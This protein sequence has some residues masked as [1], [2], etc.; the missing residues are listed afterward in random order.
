MRKK[1]FKRKFEKNSLKKTTAIGPVS[2]G[3]SLR[4]FGRDNGK[5]SYDDD[6]IKNL[7]DI[8]S[9]EGGKLIPEH[10]RNGNKVNDSVREINYVLSIQPNK[11]ES[12]FQFYYKL[13]T[14]LNLYQ[15]VYIQPFWDKKNSEKLKSIYIYDH[16]SAEIIKDEKNNYWIKL[17]LVGGNFVIKKYENIV[18]IKN[19]MYQGIFG[20]NVNIDLSRDVDLLKADKESQ[21]KKL[22]NS[23]KATGLLQ[24]TS[25]LGPEQLKEKRQQFIETN[26]TENDTSFFLIDGNTT[27]TELKTQFDNL[28]NDQVGEVKESLRQFFNISDAILNATFNSEQYSAFYKLAIEPF[29]KQLG[30]AFTLGIFTRDAINKGNKIIF[31]QA[32]SYFSSTKEK[33]EYVKV[34]IESGVYTLNELRVMLGLSKFTNLMLGLKEYDLNPADVPRVHLNNVS[35]NIADEYQLN[36]DGVE[37]EKENGD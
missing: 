18:H 1:L 32:T 2:F 8:I 7:L 24:S 11:F 36:R 4:F 22:S 35:L 20:E 37:N 13:F 15:N 28:T 5:L 27:F 29:A 30:E 23:A 25:D 21:S 12:A 33:K 9:K 10:V 26:I 31:Y 17:Y 19:H 3:S 6:Y 34:M 16:N 14:R